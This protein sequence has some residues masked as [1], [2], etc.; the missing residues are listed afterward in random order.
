M[1]LD[2]GI[3]TESQQISGAF[4]VAPRAGLVFVPSKR[5]GSIFRGGYGLFFDRVPLNV[6]GFN[7]YPDRDVTFFNPD[8]TISMTGPVS[9]YLNTLGQNR[10]RFPFVN[11]QPIDGNFSPRSAV[12]S[13]QVEQPSRTALP[14]GAAS[15][16]ICKNDSNGLVMLWIA[17][18]QPPEPMSG[19]ICSKEL[20]YRTLQAVRHP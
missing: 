14:E 4:R 9:L 3:R 15:R 11:Q 17:S 7:R 18:R 6:Y 5:T 8:G 16:P 13:A 10:V 20:A 12:W 19:P 1:A 2:L